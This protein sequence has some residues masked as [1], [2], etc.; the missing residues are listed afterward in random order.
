MVTFAGKARRETLRQQNVR[1]DRELNEIG[2]LYVEAA[3]E[4]DVNHNL[5]EMWQEIAKTQVETIAHQ[6]AAIEALTRRL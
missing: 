3:K 4:R 2:K 6:S 1:L 5:A